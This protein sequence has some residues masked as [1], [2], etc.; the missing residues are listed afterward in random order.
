MANHKPS[1]ANLKFSTADPKPSRCLPLTFVSPTLRTHT[2]GNTP[3][4]TPTTPGLERA[5]SCHAWPPAHSRYAMIASY[6]PD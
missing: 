5:T 4:H 6:L 2:P 1:M 3:Q